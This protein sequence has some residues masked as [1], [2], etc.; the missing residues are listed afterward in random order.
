MFE[1]F[2]LPQVV[3]LAT[4]LWQT[5]ECEFAKLSCLHALK[6]V[7]DAK[8]LFDEYLQEYR[9]IF[10][11]DAEDYRQSHMRQLTGSGGPGAT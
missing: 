1:H 2:R 10:D 8:H 7:P 4:T 9:N 3:S 5:D 11:V 6:T